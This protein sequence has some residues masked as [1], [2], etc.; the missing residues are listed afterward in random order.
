VRVQFKFRK[1]ERGIDSTQLII[2]G[3]V[4]SVSDLALFLARTSKNEGY[5]AH[6]TATGGVAIINLRRCYVIEVSE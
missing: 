6:K 3:T 1:Y 5:V 4:R 2:P